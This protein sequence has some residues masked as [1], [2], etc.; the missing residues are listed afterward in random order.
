[1][2]ILR[3]ILIGVSV[4]VIYEFTKWDIINSIKDHIDE[5]FNAQEVSKMR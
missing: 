5:R 4:M 1:M 3:D 2:T